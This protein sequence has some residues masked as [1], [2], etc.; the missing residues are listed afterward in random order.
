[1]LSETFIGPRCLH[2]MSRLVGWRFVDSR[3]DFAAYLPC[4]RACLSLN[5][6][7]IEYTS[8]GGERK[9]E[10]GYSSSNVVLVACLRMVQNFEV[11]P[12]IEFVFKTRR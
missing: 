11:R 9:F 7:R 2:G 12:K 1:M 4:I 10:E 5:L 6:F 3:P 8:V